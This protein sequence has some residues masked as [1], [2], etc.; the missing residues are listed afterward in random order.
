VD[1]DDN[2]PVTD[3]GFSSFAEGDKP[4]KVIG[5][6]TVTVTGDGGFFDRGLPPDAGA[7]T[8]GELYRDFV[9][10]NASGTLS[11]DI[12]GLTPNTEYEITWY[13]WDSAAIG[14]VANAIQARAASNTSGDTVSVTYATGGPVTS[15]SDFAYIGTWQSSDGSLEIDV[16][17]LPGGQP[18][19]RVCGLV[20]VEIPPSGTVI[21]IR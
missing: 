1:F 11:F 21:R 13:T 7:M 9:L 15:N 2:A 12:T 4:S 10:H 8:Y 19:S 20:I 3:G 14:T 5:A 17:D 16:I 6:Y 18:W